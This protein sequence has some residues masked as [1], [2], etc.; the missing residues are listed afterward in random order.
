MVKAEELDLDTTKTTASSKKGGKWV[1]IIIAAVLLISGSV[2]AGL[3]FTGHLGAGRENGSDA[4]SDA[5]TDQVPQKKP[6]LPVAQFLD[7]KPV[8]V[9]NFEDP[10]GGASYL[11]IDM[12]LMARDKHVLDVVA[13]QMPVV[14]N[15]ILVIMG[16][17]KYAVVKTR[18]GKEQL[19]QSILESV[20]SVVADAAKDQLGAGKDAEKSKDKSKDKEKS[21][22]K[23]KQNAGHDEHTA[24]ATVEAVYFTSFIMQ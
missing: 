20:R 19:Q 11:Q 22:S 7:L 17:Q 2:L 1:V 12:Q 24:A 3:Y 23:S 18:A 13:Q 8:F 4:E 6:S 10:S 5:A 21:K 16:S 14:R 9:S 15:N